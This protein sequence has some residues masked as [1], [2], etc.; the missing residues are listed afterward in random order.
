MRLFLLFGASNLI[1]A[2]MENQISNFVLSVASDLAGA[3]IDELPAPFFKKIT[4]VAKQIVGNESEV[5]VHL[6]SED[7][8]AVNLSKSTTNFNYKLQEKET[9]KRGEFEVSSHKST[10]G[11]SLFPHSTKD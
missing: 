5:T 1:V 4:R 3:K 9:L 10:A 7:F 8:K 6:N 11:V 2:E